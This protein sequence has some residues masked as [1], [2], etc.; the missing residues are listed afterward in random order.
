M[1]ES[2]HVRHLAAFLLMR[3]HHVCQEFKDAP[4]LIHDIHKF[5]LRPDAADDDLVFPSSQA[6]I[7]FVTELGERHTQ[8]S[9][10]FLPHVVV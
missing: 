4:T 10:L 8:R 3:P 5:L 1:H 2:S 7:R 6:F 9:S